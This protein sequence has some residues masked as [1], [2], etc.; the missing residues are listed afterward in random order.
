MFE[1]V[2]F[3]ALR[4]GCK[5]QALEDEPLVSSERKKFGA[6]AAFYPVIALLQFASPGALGILRESL[7]AS[8]GTLSHALPFKDEVVPPNLGILRWSVDCHANSPIAASSS[9]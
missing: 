2:A 9:V 6:V 8:L 7:R 1:V 3:D 5:R 4:R